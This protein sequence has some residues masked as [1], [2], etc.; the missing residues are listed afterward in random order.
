MVDEFS[1]VRHPN[2]L[3]QCRVIFEQAAQI[4][5][6]KLSTYEYIVEARRFDSQF[7]NVRTRNWRSWFANCAAAALR[8]VLLDFIKFLR[9]GAR[10]IDRFDLALRTTVHTRKAAVTRIAAKMRSMINPGMKTSAA[11]LAWTPVGTR[12]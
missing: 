6:L 10:P 4:Y 1:H 11:F 3:A 2:P 7:P 9:Y 8:P 5:S 12:R